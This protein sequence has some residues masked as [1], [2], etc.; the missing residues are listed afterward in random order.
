MSYRLF[1]VNLVVVMGLGCTSEDTGNE[2]TDTETNVEVEGEYPNV[3]CEGVD[4]PCIQIAGGDALRLLEVTNMLT[5]NTTI[6][7]GSGTWEMDNQVTIRSANGVTLIGQ[8]MD[9]TILD[10]AGQQVQTNGVDVIGDD[11]LIEGLTIQDAKKDGLRVE[12]SDGVVIRGVRA[13]WS[14]GPDS[15]NGSYGLYPVRS[16]NVLMEDC[17]CYNSSDA[18]LYI[19]Q[20][21]N[22]IVRN[23]YAKNNVAGIE[24]ENTQ[25][26]DVYGNIAEENTGG[27]LVFDLPG[28]PI[29]GRDVR[30][31]DNI[32]RN[33]N[34]SNF[35]PGGTVRAIPAGTGTVILASRRVE[36]F[37]NVYE[38]NDTA[39]IAIL[40]GLA[41][42]GNEDSWMIKRADAAGDVDDL[43]L[44]EDKDGNYY[45]FRTENIVVA[46]NSHSGSGTAPD[47]N[48]VDLRPI[49]FL[50]AV[51]YQDAE[52][53]DDVL[54]GTIG[55]SGF[56][57]IEAT[58]NSNDNHICV[59]GN[60]QGSFASLNLEETGDGLEEGNVPGL[61][62]IFQP[63]APFAPFDCTELEGG[64]IAEVVLK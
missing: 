34:I 54:Y 30:I 20:S 64:S 14:G 44:M 32:V 49:G 31:H 7:L 2:Q 38:N 17:E 12:E 50:V 46:N 36:V 24:I 3:D 19:G 47:Y 16:Q 4:D 33:N 41:I 8:G 37:D 53:V 45:N 55:E 11:F 62:D 5:D 27:L 42:E 43:S 56:D 35:A 9:E 52:A 57:P 15:D 59:G 22:V 21:I 39:D 18:G 28:N 26:A 13:T 61:D 6:V 48:S 40:N 1:G 29:V 63:A 51:I 60:D 10:F 23:N 25:Y 58:L